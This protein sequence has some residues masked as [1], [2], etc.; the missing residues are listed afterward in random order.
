MK[1]TSKA[2]QRGFTMIEILVSLVITLIGLLGLLGLQ[3]K[4]QQA[5]IEA[6]QREQALVLLGDM[7]DRL[8]ANRKVGSCYALTTGAG[9]PYLGSSSGA[10]P[11]CTGAGTASERATAD[12][13]IAEMDLLFK[14]IGERT[15][16]SANAGAV[17]G[18][19]GCISSQVNADT[20]VTY[21]LAVA[22]QGKVGT[23]NVA[24]P[25]G[26]T[27]ATSNAIGCGSGLYGTSGGIELR[28]VAWTSVRVANLR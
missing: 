25:T 8:N 2:G 22:W 17:D 3:A 16:A 13:D 10:L 18:A 27:A 21:T 7:I 15:S 24:A 9:A 12:A 5:Q 19:R 6:Y 20:S 23:I 1:T 4:S 14:G 28:R 11:A 26:A